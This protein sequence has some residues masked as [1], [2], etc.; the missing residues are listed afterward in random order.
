M[1]SEVFFF[2]LIYCNIYKLKPN[3]F[4]HRCSQSLVKNCCTYAAL[5]IREAHKLLRVK[6]KRKVR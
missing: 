4:Y 3:D 2:F 6:T 1:E 5:S